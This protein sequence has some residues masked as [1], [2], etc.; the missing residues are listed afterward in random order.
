M[1]ESPLKGSDGV[2]SFEILIEGQKIKDSYQVVSLEI[3]R[4]V[5][6]IASAEISFLMPEDFAEFPI[7]GGNFNDFIPGKKIEIL[8]GYGGENKCLFKGIIAQQ[9]VRILE[10]ANPEWVIQCSDAAVMMTLDRQ[11]KYYQNMNDSAI[12]SAIIQKYNGLSF[13]TTETSETHKQMVQFQ[14]SDWD[15]IVD[16]SK[17]N[18]LLTYSEDGKVLVQKPASQVAAELVVTYGMDI[19]T[20]DCEIASRFQ[21]SSAATLQKTASKKPVADGGMTARLPNLQG[22]VTF[23]GNAKPRLN[24]FIQ[25][26]GLGKPL[27]GDVLISG[28]YHYIADGNWQTTVEF[29]LSPDW[30]SKQ[31][32]VSTPA[33]QGLLPAVYGL[34]NGTVKKIDSDPEGE[35]RI[36]VDVPAIEAT[37]I[38]IWA[39]L[40]QFYASSDKGSFFLPEIGDEVILGFLNDDPSYP[41]ILGMVYSS[42][43]KAPFIPDATNQFK[44]IVTRSGL[45][46]GFDDQNKILNIKTPG[47]NEFILSDKEK[48]IQLKDQNGNTVQ[49]DNSGITLDSV[50]DFVIKAK[51]KIALQATEGVSALAQGGDIQ[52]EGINVKVTA[53]AA[54][55][56]EASASAALK[57]T[58]ITTVKGAMVMIN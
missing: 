58:G 51:G 17:V 20:F 55:I 57:A 23:I 43:N 28:I 13:A 21:T 31:G 5:F 48:S 53:K 40:T 36:L 2:V 7:K 33:T 44:A 3:E 4:A 34:Q 27:D 16:R 35:F 29:G 22:T 9:K 1:P 50:K 8:V 10:N 11:C 46:I 39:R 42:K 45:S 15:F 56:L 52:L 26:A 38:G 6:K 12:I 32:T 37:G 47:G 18:R 30:Y 54:L 49:M 25:L 14:S 24:S 41:V 19:L